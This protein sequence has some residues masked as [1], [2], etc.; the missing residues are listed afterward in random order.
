M[1]PSIDPSEEEIKGADSASAQVAE[2]KEVS[3]EF[4][5][6]KVEDDSQPL[7]AKERSVPEWKFKRLDRKRHN[8]E[9]ENL[10]LQQEVTDYKA[11]LEQA[12]PSAAPQAD[13]TSYYSDPVTMTHKIVRQEMQDVLKQHD[14]ATRQSREKMEYS[15]AITEA[16]QHIRSQ[17]DVVSTKEEVEIKDIIKEHDLDHGRDPLKSADTA[18]KLWRAGKGTAVKSLQKKQAAAVTGSQATSSEGW[19]QEKVAA[20]AQ[21]GGPEWEKQRENILSAYKRGDIK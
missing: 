8:A 16:V 6:V 14:N 4:E 10:R 5:S 12:T 1:S 19:T 21:K 15:E 11:K 13:A 20:L 2:P 3:A 7:Q 18:L 17:K 9:E